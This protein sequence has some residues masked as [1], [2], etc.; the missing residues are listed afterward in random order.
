MEKQI[1]RKITHYYK[2][3]V[4]YTKTT[5]GSTLDDRVVNT[6]FTVAFE[7]YICLVTCKCVCK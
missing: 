7:S 2:L 4:I 1:L 3:T 5:F 6:S